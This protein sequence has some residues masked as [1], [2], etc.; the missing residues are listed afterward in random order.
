MIRV[1]FY[2]LF[3][4]GKRKLERAA[5]HEGIDLNRMNVWLSEAGS[6]EFGV[7]MRGS[8]KKERRSQN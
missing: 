2:N 1:S 3:P 5:S 6:P 8:D 7:E 4:L